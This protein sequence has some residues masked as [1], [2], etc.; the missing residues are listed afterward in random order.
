[1]TRNVMKNAYNEWRKIIMKRIKSQILV[2]ILLIVFVLIFYCIGYKVGYNKSENSYMDIQTDTFYA[3]ITNMKDGNFSVT[4]I[5][6]N[7]IN[8]RGDFNFAVLSE[9]TELEWRGTPMLI[10]EF[11][12]GDLISITFSGAIQESDPAYIENVVKIKL[13][14]DE[15]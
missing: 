6:M 10:S 2:G 5:S 3:E 11:E 9:E 14:D 12:V 7:D 15:K 13:L 4:G 1:M 8:Y